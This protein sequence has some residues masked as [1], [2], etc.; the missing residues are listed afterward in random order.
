MENKNNVCEVC[1]SGNGKCGMC[2]GVCGVGGY[3]LV[4]WILGIIIIT[5]VFSIGMKIGELKGM[6]DGGGYG[7]SKYKSMPMMRDSDQVYFTQG[8]PVGNQ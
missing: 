8:V 4:R 1:G 3:G 7:H 5:W 6:L 2:G